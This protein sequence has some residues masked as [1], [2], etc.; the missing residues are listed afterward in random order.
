MAIDIPIAQLLQ[1]QCQAKKV[2]PDFVCTADKIL[3]WPGQPTSQTASSERGTRNSLKLMRR[4][5]FALIQ[6]P[7]R[8]VA[9]LSF[10]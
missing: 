4:I 10:A 3:G 6:I 1:T 2:L 8:M 9:Q 5:P 7:H